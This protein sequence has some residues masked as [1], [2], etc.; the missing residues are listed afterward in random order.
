MIK[1][2][3][4]W[5]IVNSTLKEW[6]A[7]HLERS[8]YTAVMRSYREELTPALILDATGYTEAAKL[9]ANPNVLITKDANGNYFK[10]PD[11]LHKEVTVFEYN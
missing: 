2:L 5:F 3:T 9:L 1:L 4:L 8:A 6:T 7:D 11:G 10:L